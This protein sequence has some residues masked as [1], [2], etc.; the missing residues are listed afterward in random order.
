MPKK[1][2]DNGKFVEVE[3]TFKC[4]SG[5]KI[6]RHFTHLQSLGASRELENIPFDLSC[7]QCEW[8]GTM[9]GGQH[10][11]LRLLESFRTPP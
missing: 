1:N 4:P 10:T 9:K 11:S 6:T 3:I 8:K 5:H 2:Q 7:S